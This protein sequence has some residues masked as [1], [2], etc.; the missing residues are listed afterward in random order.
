MNRLFSQVKLRDLTQTG[1]ANNFDLNFSK[2]FMWNRN[3][4]IKYDLSRSMHFTLQTAMN[5]NIEEPYFTPEIGKEYYEAWRDSVWSNIRKLGSPYT[6]QQVFSASWTLPINKIPLF[7]WVMANAGYNSNYNWNRSALING[8]TDVGNVA[9]T[10]GAW[11]AD[12]QLNFEAL[13]NK[14]KYLKEVNRKFSMQQAK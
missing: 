11:S 6:Y 1:S 9:T 13:Y 7:D 8:A 12:G 14:S 4:D 2:D 3:F 5:A 10:M